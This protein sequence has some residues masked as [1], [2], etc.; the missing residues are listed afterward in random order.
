MSIPIENRACPNPSC[1][2]DV[3]DESHFLLSC[4]IYNE[5]RKRFQR[6]VFG[7]YPNVKSLDKRDLFNWLMIG[8][9]IEVLCRNASKSDR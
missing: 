5:V 3:E 2:G 6:F 8:E 9:D 1:N 7:R 4:K